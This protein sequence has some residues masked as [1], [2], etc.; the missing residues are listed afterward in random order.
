MFDMRKHSLQSKELIA[1]T[2]VKNIGNIPYYCQ[3]ENERKRKNVVRLFDL[4]K[5]P[6]R[7]DYRY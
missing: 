2:L 7:I 3:I 4:L 1:E 6:L 5:C